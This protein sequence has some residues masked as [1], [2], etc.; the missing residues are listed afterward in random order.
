MT[1]SFFIVILTNVR[2]FYIILD[3]DIHQHDSIFFLIIN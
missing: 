3:A 1:V 2:I